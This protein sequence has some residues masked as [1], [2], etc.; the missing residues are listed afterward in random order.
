MLLPLEDGNE[1]VKAGGLLE[2]AEGLSAFIE[3]L[4]AHCPD[5][6]RLIESSCHINDAE[7]SEKTLDII[8]AWVA[9]QVC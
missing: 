1:W 8:D 6:V 2:D 9:D 4:R 5:N 7:F 3:E